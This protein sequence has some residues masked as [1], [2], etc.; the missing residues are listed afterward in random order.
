QSLVMEDLKFLCSTFDS[1]ELY[2]HQKASVASCFLV[3][4]SLEGLPIVTPPDGAWTEHVS[5]GVT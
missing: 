3:D 5:E 4:T 2:R 1:T